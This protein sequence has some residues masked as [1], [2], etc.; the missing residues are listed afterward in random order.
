MK[1]GDDV[2]DTK[3]KHSDNTEGNS[4]AT[5]FGVKK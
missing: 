1:E 5:S 3:E 4:S 2:L